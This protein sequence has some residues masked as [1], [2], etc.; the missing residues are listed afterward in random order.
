MSLELKHFFDQDTYT[1]TYVVYDKSTKDAVVIDPVLNYDQAASKT[2]M[3]SIDE[4]TNFVQ[5]NELNLHLILETHAHAD[6]LTGAVELKSRFPQ[7]KVAIGKHITK[8][9]S[10]FKE[11]F[12]LKDFNTNG[13]QFDLLL[14][15]SDDIQV[16]SIKLKTIFTPGHTPACS[17]YLLEDM[18]FT[19][20]ALFMPDF[21]TGR[22]DFPMGSAKD[23]Y[24]SIHEKLYK[25]PD[26]TK[27][28]T[29]HDYQPGGRDLKFESTI[30]ESKKSNIQLREETTEEQFIRFREERDAKLSAPQL[31]LPSIQIN[32]DGGKMP[33][34]EDNG[35]SYIKLPIV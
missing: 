35:T 24:H 34:A 19:G 33:K 30:G 2:S 7:A 22:C 3:E 20:D 26:D 31:L 25:L 13:V 17:S 32:I 8:V 10:T 5:G 12:N 21:G 27:V 9:Q 29:G 18:L 1:L 6:H 23:L 15:E 11:V 28:L 16:G 14:D 4:V